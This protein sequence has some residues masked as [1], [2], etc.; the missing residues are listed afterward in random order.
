MTTTAQEPWYA[1]L[2]ER[3]QGRRGAQ[4][5][6]GEAAQ[7]P[8]DK[9]KRPRPKTAFAPG[10]A[11]HPRRPMPSIE[12]RTKR[13]AVISQLLAQ[14]LAD[15]DIVTACLDEK[16]GLGYPS[17][18]AVEKT[19]AEVKDEW[20]AIDAEQAPRLKSMAVRRILDHIAKAKAQK[21]WTAV[22][23]LERTLADIQ[24]TREPIRI[25][26]DVTAE[27]RSAL[28]GAI[29]SMA[30]DLELAMADEQRRLRA[31]M[32]GRLLPA[33]GQVVIDAEVDDG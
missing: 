9:P 28:A 11:Y 31:A 23:T 29:A 4:E 13:R 19:L 22:A 1:G 12:V 14:G 21:A 6:T 10:H 33:P 7:T 3:I 32:E 27:Q 25:E 20:V 30:P 2:E 17:R 18:L 8:G 15:R 24:G 26:V 16:H 5:A